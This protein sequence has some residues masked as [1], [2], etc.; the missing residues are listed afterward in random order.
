MFSMT[1]EPVFNNVCALHLS[2]DVSD[3]S[4]GL[5]L[6]GK[7]RITRLL[8]LGGVCKWLSF[9]HLKMIDKGGAIL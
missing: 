7:R 6:S 9:R 4:G 1:G 2:F 5:S 8:L 3:G